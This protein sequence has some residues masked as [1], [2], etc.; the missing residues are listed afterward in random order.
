M[1][2]RLLTLKAFHEEESE[3]ASGFRISPPPPRPKGPRLLES[4]NLPNRLRFIS[5]DILE[6]DGQ[7]LHS[8]LWM[9]FFISLTEREI[10][11]LVRYSQRIFH[12]KR[13][14]DVR[15]VLFLNILVLVPF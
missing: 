3:Q 8:L 7:R 1:N 5:G 4:E 2:M 14:T 9:W 12:A 6:S 10:P 11:D 13:G 15:V